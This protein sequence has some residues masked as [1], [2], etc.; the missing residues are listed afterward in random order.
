MSK[1]AKD[2]DHAKNK[3]AGE[4]KQVT[5]KITGNEQLE[6]KG[7]MQSSKADLK[8]D[9]D[10]LDKVEDIKEDIAKGINHTLENRN[11]AKKHK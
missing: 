4:I 7:K 1:L 6:L 2:F 9:L 5:G 10:I 3:V 8:K 11:K